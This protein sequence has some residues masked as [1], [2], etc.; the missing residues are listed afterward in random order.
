MIYGR[1]SKEVEK[2]LTEARGDA[3]KGLD[4]GAGNQTVGEYLARWLKD[5]VKDSVQHVT[6][7]SYTGLVKKHIVPTIGRVKLDRLSP[8]PLQELYR[9]KLEADL[10][11][12]NV[13][14]IHVVL[15]WAL[16]QVLR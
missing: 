16:K 7:E 3:A 5:S 11:P 15:H 8:A 1:K 4:F 6:F 10:S 2:R 14:Y 9:S 13:Q 12:R